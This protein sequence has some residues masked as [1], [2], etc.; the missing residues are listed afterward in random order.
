MIARE[1]Y[2]VVIDVLHSDIALWFIEK[3]GTELQALL[4]LYKAISCGRKCKSVPQRT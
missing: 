4:R 1:S 2:S 3:F